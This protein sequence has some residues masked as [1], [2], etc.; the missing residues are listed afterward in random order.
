MRVKPLDDQSR[1]DRLHRIN[2]KVTECARRMRVDSALAERKLW[3]RLR[4]RRLCGLKF[5]RQAPLGLFVADFY[6]AEFNLIVELDGESHDRRMEHDEERTQW[7]G[8]RGYRVVRFL[9][10]D[11]Y[12]FTEGVLKEIAR[13][14]GREF[15]ASTPSAEPSP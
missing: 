9:N 14:C 7:L 2:P 11:V 10:E 1:S 6:C 15:D 3:P 4:N 13:V 8:E 5:R 12:Y